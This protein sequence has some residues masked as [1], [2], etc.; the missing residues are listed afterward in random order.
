MKV[1]LFGATGMVGQG[2][3]RECLLDPGVERVAG[4]RAQPDRATECQAQGNPAPGFLSIFSAIEIRNSPGMTPAFF[5]SRRLLGRHGG[6][7]LTGI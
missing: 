5:L 4:G 3:L 7:A 2:V 1:I 6:A